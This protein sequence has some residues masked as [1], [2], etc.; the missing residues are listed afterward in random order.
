L[1]VAGTRDDF[2]RFIVG[3][4]RLRDSSLHPIDLTNYEEDVREVVDIILD[5]GVSAG[6]E[7]MRRELL[8]ACPLP[9][10]MK[11]DTRNE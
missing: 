2:I 10:L 7:F 5:R 8:A 6:R 4:Y 1:R 11:G 3:H 9:G